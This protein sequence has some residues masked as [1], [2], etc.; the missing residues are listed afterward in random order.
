MHACLCA[1]D[2]HELVLFTPPLLILIYLPYI[3]KYSIYYTTSPI[4]D[5]NKVLIKSS[6]TFH[7]IIMASFSFSTSIHI[8]R[9]K[10]KK[11]SFT[12][13]SE[14]STHTHHLRCSDM[15]SPSRQVDVWICH[16]FHPTDVH[17]CL[18][19]FVLQIFSVRAFCCQ[20]SKHPTHDYRN[21]VIRR[22]PRTLGVWYFCRRHSILSYLRR[23]FYNICNSSSLLFFHITRSHN[24][25]QCEGFTFF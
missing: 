19:S 23:D 9:P 12:V 8:F 16:F 15:A 2:E 10:N 7:M 6:A 14:M 5:P 1:T 17:A 21:S 13:R 18:I 4:T 22:R 11:K 24:M 25:T 20:T 3:C